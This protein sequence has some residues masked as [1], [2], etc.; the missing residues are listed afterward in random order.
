MPKLSI[1]MPSLNV[2][3]YIGEALE[4]A[5]SQTLSDIEILCIDAGSDD[6]TVE[7]INKF[8]KTDSRVKLIHSDKRSYGYQVNLGIDTAR[9]KY[10]AV[11]ETDDYV[12]TAMY[13]KLYDLAEE[14]D[15]DYV[16]ADYA[17]F[18]TQDN[19]EYYHFPRRTFSD[20]SMYDSVICP[21]D[22]PF[23]GRDDLYLWQGI[24]SVEFLKSN[25]IR[26]SETKGAAFQDIGFLFL[27]GA[28]AKRAVYIRDIFYHYRIDREGA[29]SNLGKGLKFAYAE[30]SAITEKLGNPETV[31]TNI[32]R[33]LYARMIK[34]FVAGYSRMDESKSPAEERSEIYEW[35]KK[36][37]NYAFEKGLADE[38]LVIKGHR[39]RLGL[40]LKSE[41]A[42]FEK[43]SVKAF[44]EFIKDKQKFAIFGCGDFGFKAYRTLTTG[45]KEIVSFFDNN[46]ALWA[47]SMND[48]LIRKPEEAMELP[49]DTY[50]V[51][52][53]EAYF[54]AIRNQLIEMGVPEGRM[55]VF[56]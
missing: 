2:A 35:F 38:S 24:Y 17:A 7:I 32:L 18:F 37:I 13:G 28:Y 4:S 30:Y 36:E 45:G 44:D 40:L 12:D 55:C 9:G 25:N 27:T 42:Y 48:I 14:N 23:I 21:C 53:N 50:I 43:Y 3:D 15:A 41:E 19:G 22:Y 29:S 6:G 49:G 5:C 51:I 33:M 16:K 31:D 52:A 46:Q 11:L 20:L 56:C 54:D 34:S 47:K 10:I 8:A 26:F 39:D 1:I